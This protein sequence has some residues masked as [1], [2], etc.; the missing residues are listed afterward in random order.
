ME[1]KQSE[2]LKELGA[3]T[4]YELLLKD[5]DIEIAEIPDSGMV[6]C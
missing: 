6:F 5:T 4:H 3:D 1:E 2:S